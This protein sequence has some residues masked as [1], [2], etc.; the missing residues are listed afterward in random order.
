MAKLKIYNQRMFELMQV[1]LQMGLA[2][3]E[4]DWF[5]KI[6]SN[7]RNSSKFKNGTINF[8]MEQMI[9]ACKLH[10]CSMD[11]ICGIKET[12]NRSDKEYTGIELIKEGL[13][14][15][16]NACKEKSKIQQTKRVKK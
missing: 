16:E 7:F 3:T 4:Q 1:A 5:T 12:M 13:R 6:G 2:E 9:E 11:W 15:L 8:Q 10:N 14:Q